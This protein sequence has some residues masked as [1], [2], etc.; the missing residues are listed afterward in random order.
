[1]FR[2]FL[3]FVRWGEGERCEGNFI[4]WALAPL[5]ERGEGKGPVQTLLVPLPTPTSIPDPKFVS[6]NDPSGQEN[7]GTY[8]NMI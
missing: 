7:G 3:K 4:F 2:L 1:M 6:N 5:Q 8:K